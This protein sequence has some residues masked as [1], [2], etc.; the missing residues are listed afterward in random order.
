M[1]VDLTRVKTQELRDAIT[2]FKRELERRGESID[3]PEDR[4]SPM[5]RKADALFS[6]GPPRA[7]IDPKDDY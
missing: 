2:A 7:K 4:R 1:I 3:V 5:M 6:T